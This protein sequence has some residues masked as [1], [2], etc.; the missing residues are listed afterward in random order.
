[1]P[2]I[3]PLLSLDCARVEGMGAQSKERKG[4]HFAA[5]HSEAIVQKPQGPNIYDLKI[6]LQPSGNHEVTE[7]AAVA[8]AECS[9]KTDKENQWPGIKV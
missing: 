4:S 1:M 6:W 7:A 8:K 3:D 9:C 5:L 2:K